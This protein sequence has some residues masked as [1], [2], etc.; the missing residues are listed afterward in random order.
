MGES[1]NST[2]MQGHN[3]RGRGGGGVAPNS[4]R[5]R[6]NNGEIPK[7]NADA[8]KPQWENP[9]RDACPYLNAG[10]YGILDD[11][12]AIVLIAGTVV[13]L[14]VLHAHRPW[15]LCTRVYSVYSLAYGT[16]EA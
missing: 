4:I 11:D 13:G 2:R 15:R 5:M 16:C 14:L 3:A 8:R 12:E 7:Q 6:G 10:W 1:P 9:G